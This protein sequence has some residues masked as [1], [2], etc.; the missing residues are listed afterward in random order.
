MTDDVSARKPRTPAEKL[1]RCAELLLRPTIDK[2]LRAGV[3]VSLQQV[4]DELERAA[5]APEFPLPI[6]PDGTHAYVST[7]CVHGDHAACRRVC[8][9]CPAECQCS[10]GHPAPEPSCGYDYHDMSDEDRGGI[11]CMCQPHS[12]G[13]AYSCPEGCPTHNHGGPDVEEGAVGGPATDEGVADADRCTAC[14]CVVGSD[15]EACERNCRGDRCPTCG[16]LVE[17]DGLVLHH[18]AVHLGLTTAQELAE[19]AA[20]RECSGEEGFCDAHGYHHEP[21]VG[22]TGR[23]RYVEV[24]DDEPIAPYMCTS[25]SAGG[26]PCGV[27]IGLAKAWG[28]EAEA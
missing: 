11:A 5:A 8:K 7:Y 24:R 13:G 25:C 12:A 6:R 20:E 23:T 27:W 19:D 21:M 16:V 4:A 28:W 15:C 14:G 10:C 9:S 22:P 17:L 18:R 26:L 2:E 1:R 3:A